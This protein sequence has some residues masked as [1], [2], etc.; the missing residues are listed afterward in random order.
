MKFINAPYQLVIRKYYSNHLKCFIYSV[1]TTMGMTILTEMTQKDWD[2]FLE[3][4]E[5]M[6]Q[7]D[8]YD[9]YFP[10]NLIDYSQE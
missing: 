7:F 9:Y 5:K 2:F 10:C 4:I 3:H 6:K 1:E 8:R